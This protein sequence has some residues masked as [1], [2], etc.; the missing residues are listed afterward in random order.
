[1]LAWAD[2][3]GENFDLKIVERELCECLAQLVARSPA[4]EEAIITNLGDFW[5]AQD[6]R[7]LTP[8]SG[9]KLDVDGRS[10]KV[11]K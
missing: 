9:N 7:Q 5:H 10:G 11:G 3:V 6:D 2:E 4:T 8:G 1:M